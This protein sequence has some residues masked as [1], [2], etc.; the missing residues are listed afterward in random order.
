MQTH[1]DD[2][3]EFIRELQSRAKF[4]EANRS[5]EITA[6]KPDEKALAKWNSSNGLQV[7][8]MPDDPQ[9]I[10]R[11]SVGGGDHLPV[12]V[13]YCTIRGSVGQCIALLEKAIAALRE[14]PE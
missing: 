7:A 1:D 8:H 12:V 14:C 5:S 11:I 10:L 6:G 13:N 2:Q 3:H 9:G 4:M